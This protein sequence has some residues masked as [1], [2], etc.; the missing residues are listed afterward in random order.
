MNLNQTLIDEFYKRLGINVSFELIDNVIMSDNNILRPVIGHAFEYLVAEVIKNTLGG[1]VIDEGGDTDIDLIIVD[2]NGKQYSTQIKTLRKSGIKRGVCF[3]INLHKTHGIEQHPNNLYPI[4]W[5]CPKC[6]HEGEAFPDFLILPHPEKGILIVPKK[7]IPESES[8]PGHFADPAVFSWSS[9]WLNRWDLLGF[10]KYKGQQLERT[11]IPVQPILN[12]TCQT[13]KLTYEEL[14][15]LWLKPSNFRMIDMN[16]KG[17]IREPLLEA[18]LNSH[19]YKT[20]P[21]VGSYPKYDL[22]CSNKRIQI[23]GTSKSKTN[24]LINS[25]GVEVM[26]S[27]GNGAIRRYDDTQFDYLG[28][29]IEPKCLNE[30]LGLDMNSCHFCF[31]PVEDLPLHYRNGYEWNT[32]NKLYDVAAFTVVKQDD[33]IYLK[34]STSYSKPPKWVDISGNIVCRAPVH[35]RNIQQY[36]LDNIPFELD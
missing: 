12:K 23:K 9:E 36:K 11:S 21:P 34:P 2:K 13:V 22:L 6:H 15:T 16:L 29:V 3:D 20:K 14:L 19:G 24:P 28:I 35:F 25:L 30:S 8:Y 31:I 17:N 18:F 10:A 1:S 33:G 27:H 5:P 4:I 7:E 32:T 26:G